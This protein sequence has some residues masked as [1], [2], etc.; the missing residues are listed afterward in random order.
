MIIGL[1]VLWTVWVIS[2][3]RFQIQFDEERITQRCFWSKKTIEVISIKY[4]KTPLD[5][6]ISKE[7][8]SR[9]FKDEC[10][11]Q[12]V[13][14]CVEISNGETTIAFRTTHFDDDVKSKAN[15][16][17]KIIPYQKDI[18]TRWLN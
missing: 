7:Q 1:I 11:M 8:I 6:N 13:N 16:L 14:L 10:L 15:N 2:V 9:L 12:T 17:L 3:F 18:D 4:I 5:K